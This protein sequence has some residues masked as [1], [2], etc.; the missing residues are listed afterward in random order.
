[1]PR[2]LDY[3]GRDA[4]RTVTVADI[5]GLKSS[6]RRLAQVTAGTA[7]IASFAMTTI[8]RLASAATTNSDSAF[9]EPRTDS[10]S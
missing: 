9:F 7:A 4:V 10:S 2:I 5:V 3:N 8:D 1:M 6:G